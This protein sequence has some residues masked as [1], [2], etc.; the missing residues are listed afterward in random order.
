MAKTQKQK[1]FRQQV[2]KP[3]LATALAAAGVF[4]MV[5]AVYAEGAPAGTNISNTATATY[6]DGNPDTAAINTTSNTVVVQVAEIA[7]LTAVVSPVDDVNGGAIENG[8][9]LNYTFEVTN[10]GNAPTDVFIPDLVLENL[11]LAS[12]EIIALMV[13]QSHLPIT[14]L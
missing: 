13:L 4:N 14:P 3:I 6:E 2:Q 1:T 12:V 9:D 5:S 11:N 8:D 7:G 10:V